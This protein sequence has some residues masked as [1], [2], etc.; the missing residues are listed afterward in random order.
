LRRMLATPTSPTV[1]VLGQLV[2]TTIL[3]L[4]QAAGLVVIGSLVFGVH[5]GDP[6]GVVLLIVV[7][8]LAASG[9]SVLLGAIARSPEQAIAFG[10]VSAVAFGMLG[11]C[12]WT[13]DSVG[14]LM[15]MVGH[16]APQAWAM[17]AFVRLVFDHSG[18]VGI[19]P[20]VGVLAL[21]AVALLTLA[22]LKLRS[23]AVNE[24]TAT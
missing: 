12:M 23:V 24:V 10:I 20:D 16:I 6:F 19:L 1:V 17:D 11:G 9:A 5:W 14:P 4:G 18:I 13:L 21:F 2:S 8:S 22:A 7:L 15:R 3:G